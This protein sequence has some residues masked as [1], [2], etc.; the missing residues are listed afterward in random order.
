MPTYNYSNN[1]GET[2]GSSGQHFTNTVDNM[3]DSKLF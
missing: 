1:Y 3:A 2:S